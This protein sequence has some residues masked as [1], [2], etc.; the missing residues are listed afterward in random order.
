MNNNRNAKKN[1]K[2]G[3]SIFLFSVVSAIGLIIL[4]GSKL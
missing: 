3:K 1:L 4:P 2:Y